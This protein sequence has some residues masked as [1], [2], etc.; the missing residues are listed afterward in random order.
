MCCLSSLQ[1]N[2]PG[3]TVKLGDPDKFGDHGSVFVGPSEVTPFDYGTQRAAPV[4]KAVELRLDKR[5][6]RP[7]D[8]VPVAGVPVPIRRPGGTFKQNLSPSKKRMGYTILA[9]RRDSVD[10]LSF[11]AGGDHHGSY[12]NA[13]VDGGS[14]AAFSAL[15]SSFASMRGEVVE[16]DVGFDGFAGANSSFAQLAGQ[17]QQQRPSRRSFGRPALSPLRNSMGGNVVRP[18]SVGT[19]RHS[20]ESG[21][22][23]TSLSRP[24]SVGGSRR[25]DNVVDR[26]YPSGL[27]RSKDI[28]RIAKYLN[29]I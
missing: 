9:G 8:G 17:E 3:I 23:R 5:G 28:P 16:D 25:K 10:S 15:A 21:A 11:R 18:A 2:R 12:G 24:Q 29:S 7:L 22:A 27:D 14:A 13:S 1:E 26:L 4:K 20:M 6:R 19:M